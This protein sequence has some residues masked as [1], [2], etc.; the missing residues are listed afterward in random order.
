MTFSVPAWLAPYLDG[1]I[2]LQLGLA[3]VPLPPPIG[4]LEGSGLSAYAARS[5]G[6]RALAERSTAAAMLAAQHAS[7]RQAEAEALAA[8]LS[9]RV[10]ELEHELEL[11][12]HEPERLRG[13]VAQS[14]R[15]RRA[16]EQR[17]HAERAL[18]AELE[19]RLERSST[20]E[21]DAIRID[22]G[23]LA[24]AEERVRELE[25]DL[26]V[27]RRRADEAEQAAAAA[28]AREP[29][30]R[31]RPDERAVDADE[32]RVAA[33]EREL[34][35]RTLRTARAWAELEELR[36]L[37]RR[38]F[39]GDG[40][41]EALDLPPPEAA[42]PA[43]PA[44]QRGAGVGLER[45]DAALARLRAAAPDGEEDETVAASER[46]EA[47]TAAAPAAEPVR[48]WLEPAFATMTAQ[49]P[50][51]AGELL[52]GLLPAQGLVYPAP[53]AYDLMPGE[54]TCIRVTSAGSARLDIEFAEQPR[55]LADVS[56]RVIGNPAALA[57]LVVDGRARRLRR[58]GAARV[59]GDRRAL[60]ALFA[61]TRE[62]RA[63]HELFRAGMRLAPALAFTLAAG[64]AEPA[65]TEG[66]RFT[67][68]H[69]E[70]PSAR[71]DAYVHIRDGEPAS[72]TVSPWPGAVSATIT[73]ADESLL[74]FLSGDPG[75]DA[76]IS[77]QAGDVLALIGW[78]ERAQHG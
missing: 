24:A 19:E 43:P 57:R 76:T 37:L 21:L 41:G 12:Q 17:A 3:T 65:W 64:M 39:E 1:R 46:P 67:I 6:P 22:A 69:A 16:A 74:G 52:V 23:E 7:E 53:V 68:A 26:E 9:A 47:E 18:R 63:L 56:F 31:E 54:R 59:R 75:V 45:F 13:M 5:A 27:A 30:A 4:P 8:E 61:L 15:E 40:P 66:H 49:V 44:E 29:P 48:P 77:G 33:L 42:D 58:R 11:A 25:N 32:H 34:H 71:P 20:H 36:G 10:R 28:A 70:S 73:C 55:S 51:T 35:E 38:S 14:D 50:D 62:P 72:V 78:L 60:N 2:W